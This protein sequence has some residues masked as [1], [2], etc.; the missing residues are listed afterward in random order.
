MA[1][2]QYDWDAQSAGFQI[3]ESIGSAISNTTRFTIDLAK[4]T[5]R[6]QVLLMLRKLE[7]HL[8]ENVWPPA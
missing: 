7:E 5:S 3:T 4:A 8:M 1:T 2:R 6:E